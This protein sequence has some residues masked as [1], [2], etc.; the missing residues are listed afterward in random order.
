MSCNLRNKKYVFRGKQ[1]TQTE[2][3]EALKKEELSSREK[4]ESLYDEWKTMI[5]HDA[6]HQYARI[7]KGE[8]VTGNFIRAAKNI[9]YCFGLHDSENIAYGS[10]VLFAKDAYDVYG[11]AKGEMVY[12]TVGC[13][14]GANRNIASLNSE[15]CHSIYYSTLESNCSDMFGCHSMRKKSYCILNKQYTKEEYES[16][17]PRIIEHMMKTGE[18]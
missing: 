10:R 8:N 5:A 9:K 11:F 7:I 6:I 4:L 2:Y 17:V 3:K 14:Y 13:S 1:L 18:W 15:S 12:E 16:L